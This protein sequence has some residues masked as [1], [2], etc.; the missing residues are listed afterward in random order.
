MLKKMN[1]V[2]K[3]DTRNTSS[4]KILT[5]GQR[6]NFWDFVIRFCHKN[7]LEKRKKIELGGIWDF[8]LRSH[9]EFET[10]LD[11]RCS[12][13]S[14]TSL[15]VKL[16]KR[17]DLNKEGIWYNV[18]WIAHLR[19]YKNKFPWLSH[20]DSLKYRNFLVKLGDRLSDPIYVNDEVP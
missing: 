14:R 16:I 6:K 1:E 17:V 11:R 20:Q 10:D 2:V 5:L 18:G 3:L 15:F 19:T 7:S 4:G 9:S 12:K 13:L 8:C